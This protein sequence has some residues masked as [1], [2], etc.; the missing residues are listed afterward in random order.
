MKRFK[1]PYDREELLARAEAGAR[2]THGQ[3]RH[4]GPDWV[5][6]GDREIGLR[7]EDR[8]ARARAYALWRMEAYERGEC[9]TPW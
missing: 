6:I 2:A 4:R 3:M 9:V 7:L 1:V 5:R 8:V